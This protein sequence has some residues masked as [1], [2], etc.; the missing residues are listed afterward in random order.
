MKKEVKVNGGGRAEQTQSP[1]RR[2]EQGGLAFPVKFGPAKQV[3]VPQGE[4]PVANFLLEE[5]FVGIEL[6]GDIGGF[7]TQDSFAPGLENRKKGDEHQ[8]EEKSRVSNPNFL[9]KGKTCL[10]QSPPWAVPNPS[11]L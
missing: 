8:K 1:G 5:M 10:Q 9:Q 3:G 11:L 6:V 4:A 7:I 2:V